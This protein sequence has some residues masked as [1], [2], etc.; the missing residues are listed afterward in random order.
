MGVSLT[1]DDF[2]AIIMGSLPPS[3]DS[4]LSTVNATSNVLGTHL[5]ADD[6]ML[7]LTE[8]F[9]HHALKAKNGKKDDN[10]AFYSN[11]ASG[12]Q[13]GESSS[14]KKGTCNNCGKKGH[15][16]RDCW[17]EGGGKE[18]QGPKQK[19]KKDKEKEGKGKES[20]ATAKEDK[21]DK[22]KDGKSKDEEAWMAMIVDD[23]SNSKHELDEP[24]CNELYEEAYSCFVKGNL[25]NDCPPQLDDVGAENAQVRTSF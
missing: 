12:S 2:Y 22:S 25:F 17:K 19:A 23:T 9:K 7:S 5:S 16:K 11:D 20:A 15:W 6:L 8:E 18:G 4:Y 13:K 24:L 10:A 3:Y 21:E 14:K 1:E